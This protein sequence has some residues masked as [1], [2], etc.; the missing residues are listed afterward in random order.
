MS[1]SGD[2]IQFANYRSNASLVLL[3]TSQY[4]FIHHYGKISQ[5]WG[6]YR[7]ATMS[8]LIKQASLESCRRHLKFWL[9]R[10]TM[11]VKWPQKQAIAW[12]PF[13]THEIKSNSQD[14]VTHAWEIETTLRTCRACVCGFG[15]REVTYPYTKSHSVIFLHS[16]SF[17]FAFL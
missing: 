1:G 2:E 10:G 15:T 6:L 3:W 13:Q 16:Y 17:L 14:I 9:P 4:I 12:W 7:L 11:L 8:L 5:R